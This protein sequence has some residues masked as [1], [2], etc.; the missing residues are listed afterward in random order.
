MY[1][2]KHYWGDENKD[3]K[4]KLKFETKEEISNIKVSKDESILLKRR[5][6]T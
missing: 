6:N 2:K 1:L 5:I 3:S 4:L